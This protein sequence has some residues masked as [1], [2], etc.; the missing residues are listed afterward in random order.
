MLR[1]LQT[2]VAQSLS[3]VLTG[4]SFSITMGFMK[5]GSDIM[6]VAFSADVNFSVPLGLV[7][8]SL[9]RVARPEDCYHIHVLG[10]A[11][12]ETVLSDIRALC[13]TRGYELSYHDVGEAMANVIET[14]NFPKM[15]F[16]R[17][18]LPDLLPTEVTR[19]F[20]ADSDV[21]LMRDP[22][23][24]FAL[25]ME[26]Y[27]LAGV[28]DMALA[29]DDRLR[30]HMDDL[31]VAYGVDRDSFRN[32]YSG[33]LLFNLTLCREMSYGKRVVELAQQP[34]D[35]IL[36]PDQDIMNVLAQGQIKTLPLNY[37]VVPHMAALYDAV[38]VQGGDTVYRADEVASAIAHPALMHFAT[39]YKPFVLYPCARWYGA[40]YAL[41]RSSPWKRRLPYVPHKIRRGAAHSLPCKLALAWMKTLLYIPFGYELWW[42]VL[43]ILPCS[44]RGCVARAF[45][46]D[47]PDTKLS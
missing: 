18:L 39:S 27:L 28:L 10:D 5:S 12:D 4:Y 35:A 20:Y 3:L 26:G 44:V 38:I 9:M 43:S 32:Y 14:E 33:Q 19:V 15:A 1:F 7:C 37:C 31:C 46:W 45:A 47:E 22:A 42:A 6:H 29:L 36:Y 21:M 8:L 40:F 25:D 23:E 34:N 11:V 2:S 24:L 16:A 17:F 13:D 41:W 30:L